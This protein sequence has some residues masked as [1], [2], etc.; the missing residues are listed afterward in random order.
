VT[1]RYSEVR[2]DNQSVVRSAERIRQT[3]VNSIERIVRQCKQVLTVP[4]LFELQLLRRPC[5]MIADDCRHI[6]VF[7]RNYGIIVSII[8][9]AL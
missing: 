1:D 4:P 5:H 6:T 8:T 9:K 7:Y 2:L 3:S